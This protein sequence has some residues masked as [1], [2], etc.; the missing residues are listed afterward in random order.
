MRETI[1]G[2][3]GED[4]EVE[5]V[6][7]H[8]TKDPSRED[9]NSTNRKQ[10]QSSPALQL[11]SSGMLSL[12]GRADEELVEQKLSEKL[13][14]GFLLLEKACPCCA[15][16]LVKQEES[17]DV[18][19]LQQQAVTTTTEANSTKSQKSDDDMSSTLQTTVTPI[20][21]IPFCV[22]CQAHIVT[23]EVEAVALQERYAGKTVQGKIMVAVSHGGGGGGPSPSIPTNYSGWSLRSQASKKSLRSISMKGRNANHST[24]HCSSTVLT[25]MRDEVS[26]SQSVQ[27]K[28][29]HRS[30]QMSPA[31][32]TMKDTVE[33]FRSGSSLGPMKSSAGVPDTLRSPLSRPSISNMSSP[34]VAADRYQVAKSAP[35]RRDTRLA[36]QAFAIAHGGGDEIEIICAESTQWFSSEHDDDNEEEEE[37]AE[38]TGGDD[39][40]ETKQGQVEEM[41]MSDEPKQEDETTMRDEDDEEED[42]DDSLRVMT[43]QDGGPCE[44]EA[45]NVPPALEPKKTKVS[46]GLVRSKHSTSIN[47]SNQRNTSIQSKRSL[48]GQKA[49]EQELGRE[50]KEEKSNKE[51]IAKLELGKE[52]PKEVVALEKEG[53][54]HPASDNTVSSESRGQ[55]PENAVA[56]GSSHAQDL[57]ESEKHMN[58]SAKEEK[59]PSEPAK[60]TNGDVLDSAVDDHDDIHE[61]SVDHEDLM[62]GS[63]EDLTTEGSHLAEQE[64]HDDESWPSYEER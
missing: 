63:C 37:A 38:T 2:A 40:T 19:L 30:A 56:N 35:K 42:E 11:S 6:E 59:N 7:V 10:Q 36:R 45:V 8:A 16:P 5:A 24:T 58:D 48:A 61:I 17:D 9:N 1:R 31:L 43:S 44:T 15:T 64:H 32:L 3:G 41:T 47:R 50:Y 20:A 34:H 26:T 52:Q 12:R 54:L 33:M 27:S 14:E 4:G 13:M 49:N 28:Q 57:Q 39:A 22:T 60:Q 53:I 25:E 55:S 29:Q 62:V 46:T 23:N 51:E 21:G 18:L